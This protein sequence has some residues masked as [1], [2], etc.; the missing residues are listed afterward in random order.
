MVFIPALIVRSV[1]RKEGF[2]TLERLGIYPDDAKCSCIWI[3]AVSVGELKASVPII[4]KLLQSKGS[5]KLLITTTTITASSLVE[6]AFGERVEHVFFPYDIP[7][8]LRSLFR[9]YNP[10][11]L[12]LL[13]TELWPNLLRLCL[14][15]EIP[16][17]LINA[18]LSEHSFK[19]YQILYSLMSEELGSITKIGAQNSEYAERFLKIGYSKDTIQITGNLK[20]EKLFVKVII[21]NPAN[22]QSVP[23]LMTVDTGADSTNLP[24]WT[25]EKLGRILVY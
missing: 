18:R 1:I 8:I 20:F 21:V 5:P 22:R 2:R 16:V 3:H 13:E 25:I 9:K 6:K 7:L 14:K 11:K 12:I 24:E 10:R 15:Q 23:V 4:E 19:R 17:F